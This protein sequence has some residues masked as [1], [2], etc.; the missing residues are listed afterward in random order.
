MKRE[1]LLRSKEFWI[2]KIQN[3]LYEELEEYLK[4][5]KISKTEFAN[6]MG[7]SKGYVSQILNGDFDHKLSKLVEIS[8]IMEKTPIVKF[9]NIENCIR[10]DKEIGVE[11]I[12]EKLSININI[13]F[14]YNNRLTI[15]NK[16][17]ELNKGFNNNQKYNLIGFDE[18]KH[19]NFK[20]EEQLN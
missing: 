16:S 15:E 3:Q 10:I 6:K 7:V 8:L 20:R 18:L 17:E 4:E 14:N 9:E 11:K 2:A 13:N 19:S 12:N 1:E 5:N